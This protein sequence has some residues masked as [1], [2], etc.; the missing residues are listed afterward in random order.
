MN[1]CWANIRFGVIETTQP[2][3]FVGVSR[4][5]R[6]IV[7]VARTAAI[8]KWSF[9]LNL[10]IWE[11]CRRGF[12][13]CVCVR[14]VHVACTQSGICDP[15]YFSPIMIIIIIIS[16]R[17]MR[18]MRWQQWVHNNDGQ[19][20]RARIVA[21]RRDKCGCILNAANFA[22]RSFKYHQMQ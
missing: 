1:P 11:E 22:S 13:T 18:W 4:D 8:A 19:I 21:N 2:S 10:I 15:S 20:I 9:S 3:F 16:G 14:C 7:I 17:V 12:Y 6:D 5:R